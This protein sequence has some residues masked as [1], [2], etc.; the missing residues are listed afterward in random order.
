[1]FKVFLVILVIFAYL[2]IFVG[3]GRVPTL[4]DIEWYIWLHF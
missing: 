2:W 4:G 1:M 3:H